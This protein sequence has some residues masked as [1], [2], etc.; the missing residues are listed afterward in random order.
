MDWGNQEETSQPQPQHKAGGNNFEGP[1]R[2]YELDDDDDNLSF[3]RELCNFLVPTNFVPHK[4]MKY[5][6]KGDP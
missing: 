6:E 2:S 1:C 4:I 3:F 5:E